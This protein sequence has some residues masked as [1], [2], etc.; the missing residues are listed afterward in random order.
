[1]LYNTLHTYYSLITGVFPPP[2]QREQVQTQNC[3]HQKN[4]SKCIVGSCNPGNCTT[5][6]RCSVIRHLFVILEMILNESIIQDKVV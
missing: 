3:F 5:I 1:M 2:S 4:Y 6:L